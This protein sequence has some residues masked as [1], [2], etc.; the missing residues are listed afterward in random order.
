MASFSPNV[1][2]RRKPALLKLKAGASRQVVAGQF[3]WV[4]IWLAVTGF[5]LFLRPS[6]SGHGT[7]TQLGLPPCPSVLLWDKPC[8]GCGLTT[9]VSAAIHGDFALSWSAHP[10][11]LLTYALLTLAGL[12]CLLASLKK[13]KIDCSSRTLTV[14]GIAFLAIY[15]AH[16]AIRFA[17]S[18]PFGE[19]AHLRLQAVSKA[20]SGP[21]K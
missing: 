10:F 14:V 17:V 18:P 3:L 4:A 19:A 20:G 1:C 16:G 13:L 2:F 8:P 15:L 9:S 21:A 11:G 7:H 6:A 5:G 12:L